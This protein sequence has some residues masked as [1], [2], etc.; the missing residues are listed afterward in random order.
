MIKSTKE[1]VNEFLEKGVYYND[2]SNKF[3]DKLWIDSEELERVI[4]LKRNI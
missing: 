4:N 1:I 2:E 3:N